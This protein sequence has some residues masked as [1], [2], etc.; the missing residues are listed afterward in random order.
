MRVCFHGRSE[1]YQ[2]VLFS[3]YPLFCLGIVLDHVRCTGSFLTP[4][5]SPCMFKRN[6]GVC[7]CVSRAAKHRVEMGCFVRTANMH[8]QKERVHP[9]AE[10]CAL[11]TWFRFFSNPDSF[12]FSLHFCLWLRLVL[13]AHSLFGIVHLTTFTYTSD[14]PSRSEIYGSVSQPQPALLFGK[15]SFARHTAIPNICSLFKPVLNK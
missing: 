14:L 7:T 9:S 13:R 12:S 2:H 4:P 8:I 1:N 6:G 3:F 10:A 11:F 15:R 5:P